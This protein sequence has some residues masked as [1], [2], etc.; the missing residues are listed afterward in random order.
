MAKYNQLTTL[1]FKGLNIHLGKSCSF[2]SLIHL[3]WTWFVVM[4]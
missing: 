1:P 3:K 2:C 4:Q